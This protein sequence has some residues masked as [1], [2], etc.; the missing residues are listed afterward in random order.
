MRGVRK[1]V[2]INLFNKECQKLI[3]HYS[4]PKVTNKKFKTWVQAIKDMQSLIVEIDEILDKYLYYQHIDHIL[5]Y[6]IFRYFQAE[7]R[8]I[9]AE[10]HITDRV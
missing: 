2:L 8:L 5:S 3:F 10:D 1:V 7:D 4:H 9:Y 6:F